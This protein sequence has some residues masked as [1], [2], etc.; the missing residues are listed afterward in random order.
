[1]A[2]QEDSGPYPDPKRNRDGFVA[3][4]LSRKATLLHSIAWCVSRHEHDAQD[5]VQEMWR[6]FVEY[7]PGYIEEGRAIAWIAQILIRCALD[8]RK[9][10]ARYRTN[11]EPVEVERLVGVLMGELDDDEAIG[12]VREVLKGDAS[13]REREAYDWV[14]QKGLSYK[15]AAR[16]MRITTDTVGVLVSRLR[17]R[18]EEVLVRKGCFPRRSSRERI[19]E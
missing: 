14:L 2:N 17:D 16:Q 7:L 12:V 5:A 15:E 6:K 1:M 3:W 11:L 19:A 18:V 8:I 13:P 4:V 10:R 9:K